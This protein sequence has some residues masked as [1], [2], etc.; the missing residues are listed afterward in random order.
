MV[1]V[2]LCLLGGGIIC[3]RISDFELSFSE[4]ICSELTISK[5]RC[6]C[7]IIYRP[8]GPG[9]LSIFFEELL[10]SLSK[11]ILKYQS[12][13]IMGDLNIDLEIK[14]FGFNKLDQFCDLFNL[15]KLIKTETCFSKSHKSLIDFFLTNKPLSFQKTHLTKAGLGDYHKLI[16]TFFKS[17]F[18][19][20]RLKVITYRNYKKFDE[21]VFLNYLQKLEIKLDEEN[22]ESSYSL[23]SDKLLEVVNK[24]APLKN[25]VLRG[26]HSP[27][28]TKEFQK[29]IYTRNKLKNKMNQN[30]YRENVLAYKK[31]R[32]ICV[33]LRR[34]SLKKYLKSITEKGINNT[35][36][37]W[38][39]I[40]P[41]LTNIKVSLVVTI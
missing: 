6:L 38:K 40:N 30:P 41:F 18:E 8:P 25:T 20:L 19:R 1:V 24:H 10:E 26:N 5:S 33:S 32:N 15:T 12:I 14:G 2:L 34:K 29:A 37:F 17:H 27:F 36:S 23:I 35:K 31:Q 4:C 11:G 28:V 22:S 3:K 39:F 7:F 13:I 16:S 21:N 9:N